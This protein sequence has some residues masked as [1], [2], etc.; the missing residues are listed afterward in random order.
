[1]I[2]VGEWYEVEEV[3]GTGGLQENYLVYVVEVHPNGAVGALEYMPNRMNW[4]HMF[5]MWPL[6]FPP[7]ELH[8]LKPVEVH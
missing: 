5:G 3:P 8:L 6:P 2:H 4:N 1:M 7:N